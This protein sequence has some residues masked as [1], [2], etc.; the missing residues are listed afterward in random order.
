MHVRL[1]GEFGEGEHD[2]RKDVDDDLDSVS[3]HA[4]LLFRCIHTCWL[5][6]PGCR[7][8][9]AYPPNNPAK[10]LS[11]RPSFPRSATFKFRRTSIEAL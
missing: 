1:D 11:Y 2:S 4:T 8:K 5:T 3:F 9:T 7:P 10:K 6:L